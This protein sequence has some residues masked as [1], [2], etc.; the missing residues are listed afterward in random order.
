VKFRGYKSDSLLIKISARS[1]PKESRRRSN[2]G[3]KKAIPLYACLLDAEEAA[4]DG[5]KKEALV[6]YRKAVTRHQGRFSARCRLG[7]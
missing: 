7:G 2:L 5:K 4:L 6:L 1:M 3:F